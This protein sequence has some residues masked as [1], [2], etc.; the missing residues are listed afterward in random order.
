MSSQS[1]HQL[2]EFS[3]I[4]GFPSSWRKHSIF[5]K[6]EN[7]W[8]IDFSWSET[9]TCQRNHASMLLHCT[10]VFKGEGKYERRR[11]LK[12]GVG[13]GI[14]WS[15]MP[16]A[17]KHTHPL[18]DGVDPTCPRWGCNSE[19]PD[20]TPAWNPRLWVNHCE[21]FQVWSNGKPFCSTFYM[22][23]IFLIWKWDCSYCQVQ[24]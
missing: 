5:H 13:G 11:L 9:E 24:L 10:P 22:C 17:H 7:K 23:Y 21:V 19:M 14:L 12:W 8:L 6:H 16:S 20:I 2:K 18:T 1:C 15:G 4:R 3:D